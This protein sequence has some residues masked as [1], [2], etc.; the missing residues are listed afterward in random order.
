[1]PRV[2]V[3]F[4]ALNQIEQQLKTIKTGT[5]RIE[6]DFSDT[7]RSLDWDVRFSGDINRTANQI[8]A[9]LEAFSRALEQYRKFAE[10]SRQA[11]QRLDLNREQPEALLDILNSRLPFIH[12]PDPGGFDSIL[13]DILILINP[14]NALP[15]FI[16]NRA[17]DYLGGDTVFCEKG[18]DGVTC[19]RGRSTS[20]FETDGGK[21]ETN[22]YFGK[23]EYKNKFQSSLFEDKSTDKYKNGEWKSEEKK[24]SG[25]ELEVGVDGSVLSGD[26]NMETG[27][28]MFGTETNAEISA[29]NIELSGKGEVSIGPDGLNANVSGKAM[30]SAVEGKVEGTINIF[31]IEITPSVGGYAGAYGAEGKIGIEDGDFVMEGGVAALFGISGGIRIGVNETGWENAIDFLTFWD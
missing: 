9:E 15:Q 19:W 27:D 25:V 5:D 29:G 31:G 21:I 11:Y 18:E 14:T 16:I 30:V 13:R 3:D 28:D 23:L 17:I 22:G 20:A 4:T 7:I 2:Y 12:I 24:T 10:E 1:M 26:F 8:T 6:T